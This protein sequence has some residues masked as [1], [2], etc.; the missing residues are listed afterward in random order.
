M[1]SKFKALV[2]FWLLTVQF[3][4][5]CGN[6]QTPTPAPTNI[7]TSASPTNPVNLQEVYP[8]PQPVEAYNP[9]PGPSAGVTNIID[10]SKAEEL[11][12]GGQVSK[13]YHATTQHV[14]LVLKD[15]SV[16]LTLEPVPD[17]LSRAIEKCG[18]PC[19]DL[20]QISP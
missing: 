8:P 17:D 19:K 14:T 9:Y 7:P 3:L 1:T 5:A 10:W 15:G 6:A 16:A 12:L 4:A 11:I 20:E 18:E 2:A 13:A